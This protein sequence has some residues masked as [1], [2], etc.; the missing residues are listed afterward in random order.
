MA[1]RNYVKNGVL[2]CVLGAVVILLSGR[3]GYTSSFLLPSGALFFAVGA[4][5]LAKGLR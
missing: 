1:N 2:V 3:L 4:I 5:A